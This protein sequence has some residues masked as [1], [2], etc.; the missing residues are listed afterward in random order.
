MS[1]PMSRGLILGQLPPNGAEHIPKR[2]RNGAD[3]TQEIPPDI[4]TK[5]E[6]RG[7]SEKT[8]HV[9]LI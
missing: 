3:S 6:E 9:R 4:I 8:R 1:E 2:R 5:S 7:P